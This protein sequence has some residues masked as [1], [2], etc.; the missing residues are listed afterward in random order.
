MKISVFSRFAI[1][2]Q[3]IENLKTFGI[4]AIMVNISGFQR[5]A[6]LGHAF[7]KE[8]RQ[9]R[10]QKRPRKY[11]TTPQQGDYLKTSVAEGHT[12]KFRRQAP[13]QFSQP[14]QGVLLNKTPQNSAGKL[15]TNSVSP[16]RECY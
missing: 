4:I 2:Q 3:S 12:P 13:N 15:P 14:Q 11:G 9:S 10:S 7:G 6:G 5:M 8:G 1:V 16:S